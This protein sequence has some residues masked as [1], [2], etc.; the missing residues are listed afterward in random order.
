VATK[1]LSRFMGVLWKC[2]ELW[3]GKA[4]EC[5]FLNGLFYGNL[6]GKSAERH[7]GNRCLDCEVAKQSE[8]ST[9]AFYVIYLGLKS[10]DVKPVLRWDHHW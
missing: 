8:N 2:F 4:I 10:S 5:S 6:E 9:G 1:N 7:A 3:A